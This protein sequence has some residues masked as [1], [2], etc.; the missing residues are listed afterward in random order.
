MQYMKYFSFRKRN[1][2][3]LLCR[4]STTQFLILHQ[5]Y[6]KIKAPMKYS[7]RRH[8][9]SRMRT[10]FSQVLHV[11]TQNCREEGALV[12]G[13]NEIVTLG[14]DLRRG[15]GVQQLYMLV[16]DSFFFDFQLLGFH[17]ICNGI[18]QDTRVW[19]NLELRASREGSI[20]YGHRQQRFSSPN[21]GN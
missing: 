16:A 18:L 17:N 20:T 21:Q 2:E 19:K 7:V 15:Q 5:R 14:K 13:I 3:R 8:Y 4:P 12:T 11:Y 1:Q 9:I 6:L 10:F